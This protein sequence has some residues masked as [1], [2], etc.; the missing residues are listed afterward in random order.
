MRKSTEWLSG[1]ITF[2]TKNS[3]S[4]ILT[5]SKFTLFIFNRNFRDI[6]LVSMLSTIFGSVPIAK[7]K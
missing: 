3:Y 6:T 1:L 5:L 7:L 2:L 4:I